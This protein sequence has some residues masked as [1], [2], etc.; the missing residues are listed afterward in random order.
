MDSNQIKLEHFFICDTRIKKV[1]Y[2][3][4]PNESDKY[5]LDTR[6]KYG[7]KLY[8][9]L[10]DIH[11]EILT[12][13]N[14]FKMGIPAIRKVD[15]L[16]QIFEK[17]LLETN[18]DYD[19]MSNFYKVCISNMKPEFVD[20]V[21]ANTVGHK[22]ERESLD[23]LL[24][25]C[26]SLNELLH[27]VHAYIVNNENIYTS[28]PFLGCKQN[29]YEYPI[30]LYG[31]KTK[32]S[33]L[34]Y[35]TIPLD[36]DV[37]ETLI[38]GLSSSAKTLMMVRDRGHALSIEIEEEKDTMKISYHIPKLCNIEM[39]NNLPGINKVD[40]KTDTFAGANGMFVVKKENFTEELFKFINMVP[41]DRDYYRRTNL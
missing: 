26:S 21:K 41:Q 28:V 34:I 20:R 30:A 35:N 38:V 39:V 31:R 19:K 10:K 37:G 32:I 40:E 18:Y 15:D 33:E 14:D 4:A 5:N 17:I 13:L 12:I 3:L 27:A 25:N 16:F 36:L 11:I 9:T 29:I 6:I 23:S 24:M 8:N 2:D 1:L 22:I 7:D